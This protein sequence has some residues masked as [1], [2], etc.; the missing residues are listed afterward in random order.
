ME[1][2]VKNYYL[3]A[4]SLAD[5][6]QSG[7]YSS[8]K[9]AKESEAFFQRQ[10]LKR[11]K[12]EITSEP[13]MVDRLERDAE[14]MASFRA[15]AEEFKRENGL[16]VSDE[17]AEDMSEYSVLDEDSFETA[18]KMIDDLKEAYG[19]TTEQAAGFVGNIW[20]ETGGYKWMEELSPVV[21]GSKGGLGFAQWTAS[22]RRDFESL[23]DELGGLDPNSY[24]GNWAMITE[25]FDTT[26][27]GALNKILKAETVDEAAEATSVFYLR[28]GIP[29]LKQRKDY[30]N[31]IYQA[32][33]ERE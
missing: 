26:E 21:K 5:K 13:S 7:E 18:F 15:N 24:E 14:R 12:E 10:G 17:V 22:R 29:K 23:L 11:V 20:H 32:Y 16:L 4:T 30:A 8:L 28:P 2:P 6:I 3:N 31:V 33:L 19:M 9:Q 25:E 1:T 27:R